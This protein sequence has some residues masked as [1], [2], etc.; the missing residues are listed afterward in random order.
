MI[1]GALALMGRGLMAIPVIRRQND[2][3]VFPSSL[4][5]EAYSSLSSTTRRR[6][7]TDA[8]SLSFGT[9]RLPIIQA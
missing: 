3:H 4:M 1:G 5:R 8:Q 6:W 2:M 7:K 9:K